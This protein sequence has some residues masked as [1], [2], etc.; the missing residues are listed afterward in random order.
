MKPVRLAITGSAG[1]GKTT[2]AETL[3]AR[4]GL[5]VVEEGMRRRLEAGLDPHTLTKADFRALILEL[6][7]EAAEA[8]RQAVRTAG[9]FV[10]DR[11]PADYIAFWLYYGLAEDQAATEELFELARAAAREMDA[12]VMLPWG[13]IPL[14][15]DGVRATNRWWQLHYHA[16]LDGL[17]SEQFQETTLW[18]MPASV[19]EPAARAD[20][21]A[22]RLQSA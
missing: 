19:C 14:Q 15:D 16:L 7:H 18:R 9:G 22:A 20:W 11:A 17:L 13:R 8:Q 4:L 1:V 10:A 21:I 2:L 12:I 3:G 5:P 6:F